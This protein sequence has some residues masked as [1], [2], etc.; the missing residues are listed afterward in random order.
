[1]EVLTKTEKLGPTTTKIHQ[2]LTVSVDVL[3]RDKIEIQ[4]VV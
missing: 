3:G 4:I 1:M 2:H